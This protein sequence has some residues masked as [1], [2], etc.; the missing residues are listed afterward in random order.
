MSDSNV[1]CINAYSVGNRI[2]VFRR[3]TCF[4]GLVDSSVK[5]NFDGKS[6]LM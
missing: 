3:S 1:I 2:V 5:C 4:Y 6:K